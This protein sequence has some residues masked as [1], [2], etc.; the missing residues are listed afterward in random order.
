MRGLCKCGNVSREKQRYCNACHA[1]YQRAHR[2][3][4]SELSPEQRKKSICRSLLHVY[5]RRG[6][7]RRSAV[8]EICGVAAKTEAH[9][10]NYD[11]PLVVKWLCR[12]CHVKITT[13]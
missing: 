10:E 7:I 6:R 3:R 13:S 11:H 12:P 8:C 9:H 2:R 4:H 5:V 1:A